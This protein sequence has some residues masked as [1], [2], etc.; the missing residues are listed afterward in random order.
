LLSI[1]RTAYRDAFTSLDVPG[2]PAY[3]NASAQRRRRELLTL[4]L[5]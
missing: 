2:G 5:L 4:E 1:R 3:A